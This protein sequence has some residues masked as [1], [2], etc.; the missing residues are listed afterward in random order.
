MVH[1]RLFDSEILGFR[2]F[3][4]L[5]EIFANF[6]HMSIC[7]HGV[8]GR[9][10]TNYNPMF[11]NE[12]RLTKKEHYLSLFKNHSS[13]ENA[14]LPTFLLRRGQAETTLRL[15]PILPPKTAETPR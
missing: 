15:T 13:R 7:G 8:I 10:V 2:T 12:C 11:Y 5:T 4:T 3:S 1:F 9:H 6:D 14:V